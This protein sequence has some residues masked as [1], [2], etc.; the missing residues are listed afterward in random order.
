M[1]R[2]DEMTASVKTIKI[3]IAEDNPD[4]G[5]LFVDYLDNHG[6]DCKLF[7]TG[8]DFL[9][10]LDDD[11]DVAVIDANMTRINGFQLLIELRRKKPDILALVISGDNIDHNRMEALERG[12]DFFL[13]KPVNLEVLG[14]ILEEKMA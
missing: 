3:Y 1:K 5:T 2:I 11:F 9:D 10:A 6:Y 14:D 7:E 8:L 4:M 12:A 13:P